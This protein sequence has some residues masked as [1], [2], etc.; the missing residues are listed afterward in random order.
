MKNLFKNW[1]LRALSVFELITV[2]SG[3]ILYTVSSPTLRKL[4]TKSKLKHK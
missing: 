3:F 2:L 4:N 1:L